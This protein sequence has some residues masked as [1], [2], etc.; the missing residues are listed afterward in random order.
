[1]TSQSWSRENLC[2]IAA[3]GLVVFFGAFRVVGLQPDAA[4]Y[5]GL[6]RQVL[7]TDELWQLRGT[8]GFFPIFF[9][10]PPYFFQ[11]GALVLKFLGE[12]DGAARA[13]GGIPGFLGFLIT[14]IWAGKKWGAGIGLWTAFLLASFGHYTKF[15]STVM[16]EAP[17]SLGTICA[18]IGAF[19]F[20]STRRKRYTALW[21]A[22]LALT[23]A[24]KGVVGF[25]AWG[26]IVLFLWVSQLPTLRKILWTIV[27]GAA[28]KMPLLFWTAL[29]FDRG[30]FEWVVGYW[31]Q[32]VGISFTTNRGDT[33]HAANGDKLFF[34]KTIVRDG[35]P[36]WWTV[37]AT[38]MALW[39]KR[40]QNPELSR[41][42][43]LATLMTIAFVLPFSLAQFQ[44]GH[45]LHPIYLLWAPVGAAFMH[46]FVS[47]WLTKHIPSKGGLRLRWSSLVVVCVFMMSRSGLSR[48]HN[49]GQV[50][51]QVWPILTSL[52]RS[53]LV[54]VPE[55]SMDPY[56]MEANALW[57]WKGQAWA[58]I[59]DADW[60]A[61]QENP[62]SEMLYALWDPVGT[63]L[64]IDAHCD[65]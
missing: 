21:C 64:Q 27:S 50:F 4:L 48:T 10:H 59:S 22:G 30:A 25:G 45:Y 63:P 24:S 61:L 2:W 17:L 33:S 58:R 12:S 19:E 52:P 46:T 7:S 34:F 3:L 42:V 8:S 32:Q 35:W 11:W 54:L 53:C 14:V 57:Y 1:M 23:S 38:G 40:I 9:E 65:P 41:W 31:M 55:S 56:R 43:T 60:T 47:P 5:A 36:W 26:G 6:S 44:L 20:I 29:M 28:V 15:A 13:I 39:K 37:P 51:V 18:A 62:N 16:L 49:R